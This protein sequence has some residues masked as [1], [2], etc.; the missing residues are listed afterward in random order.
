MKNNKPA[1][2]SYSK[3]DTRPHQNLRNAHSMAGNYSRH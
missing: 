1:G 3:P 2:E